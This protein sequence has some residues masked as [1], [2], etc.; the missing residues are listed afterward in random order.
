M[1]SVSEAEIGVT[2]HNTQEAAL[3]MT[4]LEELGHP[5]TPTPLQVDN[6]TAEGYS[7]ETIKPKRYISMDKRY[8]LVQDRLRQIQLL[9]YF[10]PGNTNL[11]DPFTKHQPPEHCRIM[12][13][14]YY[15][16]NRTTTLACA[17]ISILCE[18]LLKQS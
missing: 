3:I 13:P 6:T 12:R 16:P 8:H 9:V 15:L 18:I 10:P 2:Y 17:T 14:N 4:P 1:G 11:A 7:N 5:Q